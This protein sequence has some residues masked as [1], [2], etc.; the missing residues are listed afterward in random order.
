LK[1]WRS[2][3]S[4]TCVTKPFK[5]NFL[6]SLSPLPSKA[7]C[8]YYFFL[9]RFFFMSVILCSIE[10]SLSC[11][12]LYSLLSIKGRF[13]GLP[14]F[15]SPETFSYSTPPS[16]TGDRPFTSLRRYRCEKDG[17]SCFSSPYLADSLFCNC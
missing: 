4:G 14:N 11:N 1:V 16:R 5:L 6:L 9:C 2:E 13:L 3:Y 17:A 10:S 7:L 15:P 8:F 12:F